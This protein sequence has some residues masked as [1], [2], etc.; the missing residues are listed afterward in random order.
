MNKNK[1]ISFLM[2]QF[3][4]C[5][6]IIHKTIKIPSRVSFVRYTTLDLHDA[7]IYTEKNLHTNF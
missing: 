1:K 7:N 3:L 5:G 2:F 4:I 6:L